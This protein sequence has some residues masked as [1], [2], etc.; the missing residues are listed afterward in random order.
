LEVESFLRTDAPCTR[1]STHQLYPFINSISKSRNGRPGRFAA[2]AREASAVEGPGLTVWCL[3]PRS[4]RLPSAPP[5]PQDLV[6]PPRLRSSRLLAG[7]RLGACSPELSRR[8]PRAQQSL[9]KTTPRSLAGRQGGTLAAQ[10]GREVEPHPGR[11]A[12]AAG[13]QG[14]IRLGPHRADDGGNGLRT[15][16][17]TSAQL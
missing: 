9:N 1:L 7:R 6:G 2:S 17:S 12:R 15:T 10:A 14:H 3:Q 8:R 5:S 16:S 4:A 13:C 11:G